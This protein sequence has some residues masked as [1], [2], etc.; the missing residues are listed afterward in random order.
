MKREPTSHERLSGH[1]WES[2]YSNGPAPWDIGKP[3]AAVARLASE[4]AFSG[5][6]L[7]AGCGTGENALHIAALGLNVFGVD[8]AETAVAMARSK[9]QERGIRAEFDIADALHLE[10]LQR[11]FDTIIDCGLFHT[12]DREERQEYVTSL[13][14]VTKHG[15]ALFVLCFSDEGS[16][17]GP[18]P[19]SERDLRSSFDRSKGWNVLSIR[20]ERLQTRLHGRGASGWLAKMSR[21]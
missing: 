18:H 15:A 8:V 19:V 9:A 14:S 20:A 21:T 17:I 1:P 7:D 11:T 10:R 16:D 6:V 4:G 5:A 13:G 12:F 2:S 3:Q